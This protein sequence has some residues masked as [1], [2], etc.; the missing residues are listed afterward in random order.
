MICGSSAR[1][2]SLIGSLRAIGPRV[3]PSELPERGVTRRLPAPQIQI[4]NA[5]GDR[6]GVYWH[7]RGNTLI[8]SLQVWIL[9]VACRQVKTGQVLLIQSIT[10]PASRSTRSRSSYG[11]AALLRHHRWDD[12]RRS[13]IENKAPL[14]FIW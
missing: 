9:V 14:G 6:S 11:L 12:L 3:I 5:Y 10:D 2:V 7:I 4:G 1:R 8:R 13:S